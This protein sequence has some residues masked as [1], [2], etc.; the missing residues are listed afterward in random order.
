MSD[1]PRIAVLR[2]PGMNCE[3]ETRRAVLAAGAL[4]DLFRWNEPPSRLSDYDGYVLP[5]GFSYQDRVRAGA[6][7]AK[8]HIVARICEEASAGKPV[9]GICNG[10]QIL[11][12]AGLV[13][14]TR[15]GLVQMGLATNVMPGRDGYRTSW[16]HLRVEASGSAATSAMRKGDVVPI[17]VAHAEG[18]F[19]TTEEGLVDALFDRGQVVMT[20]AGPGGA[21]AEGFPRNP[22]G[23][24]RNL[25]AVSNPEGN[26]VAMMP[27]PERAAW[28]S[29]VPERL[30]GEWGARR[31]GARGRSEMRGPGPGAAVL[32]S[33]VEYCAGES[34]CLKT[35]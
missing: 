8:D 34:R 6:I 2:F 14:G 28:L 19:V 30:E 4:C 35:D 31:R 33:L 5:G 7:A 32:S 18:R 21:A 13:P 3:A 16:T 20:Y 17:P 15:E 1:R 26:V 11:L 24:V 10:A 27:H 25:A 29:Q 23:S 22:N 12:E 9:L